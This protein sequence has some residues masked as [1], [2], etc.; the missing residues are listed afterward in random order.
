M[1]RRILLSGSAALATLAPA[2]SLLQRNSECTIEDIFLNGD[3]TTWKSIDQFTR[4]IEGAAAVA[5]SWDVWD[6]LLAAMTPS[7]PRPLL[8]WNAASHESMLGG[9]LGYVSVTGTPPDEGVPVLTDGYRYPTEQ[10]LEENCYYVLRSP[11]RGKALPPQPPRLSERER[12]LSMCDS[13]KRL[14]PADTS[15]G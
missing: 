8:Q 6:A 1:K 9:Y 7:V 15:G 11:L 4:D 5:I 13:L 14:N 2:V 10:F 3:V 12:L